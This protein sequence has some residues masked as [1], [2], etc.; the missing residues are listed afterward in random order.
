M[1]ALTTI[2]LEDHGQDFVEWDVDASNTVVASRPFQSWLW[3][4]A[5]ILND[6]PLEVG[7][8]IKLRV[9]G[10]EMVLAYPVEDIVHGA[11]AQ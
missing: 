4:G 9:G 1:A 11:P 6:R 7:D 2:T 3:T 10:R 5:V 8:T